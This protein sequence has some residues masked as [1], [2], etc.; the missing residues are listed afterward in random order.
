MR[1]LRKLSN[2]PKEGGRANQGASKYFS[3][4]ETKIK[5]LRILKKVNDTNFPGRAEIEK[6]EREVLPGQTREIR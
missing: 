1:N 3:F 6:G 5:R 2:E 4:N